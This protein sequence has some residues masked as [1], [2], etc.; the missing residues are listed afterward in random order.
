MFAP[1]FC[2]ARRRFLTRMSAMWSTS[3]RGE[4]NVLPAL[5]TT[6]ANEHATARRTI[7]IKTES[8]TDRQ[9][10]RQTEEKETRKS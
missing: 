9:T 4:Q 2:G 10:D 3:C 7:N 1:T 6:V 8:E 5:L